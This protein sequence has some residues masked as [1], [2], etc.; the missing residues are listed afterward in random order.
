MTSQYGAY[1]LRAEVARLCV[2]MHIHTQTNKYY[3]L[4]FPGN[5]DSRTR[6][7][8]MLCLPWLFYLG[9]YAALGG[10]KPTFRDHLSMSSSCWTFRPLKWYLQ[11]LF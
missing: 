11:G 10:F 4:L 2:C 6:L 7:S 1:A 3:L 8:V 5:N 9:C